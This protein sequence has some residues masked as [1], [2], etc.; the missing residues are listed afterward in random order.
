VAPIKAEWVEEVGSQ[1]LAY[2]YSQPHWSSSTASVVAYEKVSLLGVPLIADRLTGYGRVNPVE[3]REIFIR[4]A[5]VDQQW[6]PLA[7]SPAK[8]LMEANR[9]TWA[10]AEETEEK[11]RRRMIDEYAVFDFFAERLPP[12]ISSGAEFEKWLRTDTALSDTLRFTETDLL[13]GGAQDADAFPGSW[14]VGSAALS[15]T[16]VFEPNHI[17]DGATLSI[18]LKLLAGLDP[19]PFSWQVPGLRAEL[20]TELIRSLPKVRR[21]KLVPAPDWAARA[22]AWLAENGEDHTIRFAD[23]LGRALVGLGANPIPAKDWDISKVPAH[24]RMGFSIVDGNREVAF[25]KE[26]SALQR[27][28][29]KQVAQSLTAA[30][31][32]GVKKDEPPA[33]TWSF[34]T[35]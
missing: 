34:G 6:H 3:A 1:L 33:T 4:S 9:A 27:K 28:F 31:A 13:G 32:P 21:K 22:M 25:G 16:Y 7:S 20:A 12:E 30:K 15:L 29:A 17:R 23:E 14:P 24:L 19:A 10:A 18:P 26:L 2:S 11:T 35:H 5:L 8:Q